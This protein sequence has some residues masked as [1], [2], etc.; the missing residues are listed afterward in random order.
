M[1]GFKVLLPCNPLKVIKE[2][3][4]R[5]WSLPIENGYGWKSLNFEDWKVFDKEKWSKS[6]KYY[7]QNGKLD[8]NGTLDDLN[9]HIGEDG[10]VETSKIVDDIE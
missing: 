3:Y 5:N 1:F 6:R 4:G 2:D 9:E 10:V 7:F 8:V